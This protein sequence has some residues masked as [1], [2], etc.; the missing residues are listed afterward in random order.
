MDAKKAKRLR[1]PALTHNKSSKLQDAVL[2]I[3]SSLK[4]ISTKLKKI[5]K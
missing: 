2:G 1:K 4:D 3:L 5:N